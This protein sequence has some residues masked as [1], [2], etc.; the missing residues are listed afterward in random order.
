[1]R[2]L[3]W[4]ITLFAVATAVALAVS[5]NTG[6]VLIVIAPWRVEV[7]L[8]VFVIGVVLGCLGLYAL[9]RL[10]ITTL[11]LPNR[12]QA[13]RLR[14]SRN[15]ARSALYQGLTAYFEGNFRKAERQ[16]ELA[17][18][19]EESPALSAV[20]AARAAH[21]QRHYEARDRYLDKAAGLGQEA[22]LMHLT[23]RADLLLDERRFTEALELLREAH[24][25]APKQV[26]AHQ[27]LLK[28]QVAT[29]SWKA[30]LDT[31]DLLEHLSGIDAIQAERVRRNAWQQLLRHNAHHGED[32]LALWRS[33]PS[34]VRSDNVLAHT[35]AGY[36]IDL[37]LHK[38]AQAIIERN[39]EKE[40]DS[41]LVALYGE[42]VGESTLSQIERAE[43]W[44]RDHPENAVLLLTLA[45]LCIRQ[46]LWGKAQS[47]L[48]A[49]L[50]IEHSREGQHLKARLM[51]KIGPGRQTPRNNPDLDPEYGAA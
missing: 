49:S 46:S 2:S 4:F 35:A 15:R 23:T 7:S 8:A 26:R 9:S 11:S 30:V 19:A 36:L 42:C 3:F 10:V 24:R 18:E 34:T 47:Y 28:A 32:L 37:G 13:Y 31:V 44:L 45:K 5:L 38:E 12:V 14:R 33:I 1:M 48:D 40:W 21:E 50:F 27:L 6:Y 17:L 22:R 51:E 16:A 41:S 29:G 20:V 39:L 43:R 25:A